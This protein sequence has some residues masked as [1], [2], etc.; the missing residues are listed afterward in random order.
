MLRLGRFRELSGVAANPS[1]AESVA[2]AAFAVDVSPYP[3]E[4]R[5]A[6]SVRESKQP[7]RHQR[8]SLIGH[9]HPPQ[10]IALRGVESRG[11]DDEIRVETFGDGI[12][13]EVKRGEVIGVAQALLLPRDVH[14]EPHPSARA[15]LG[16][17]PVPG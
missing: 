4:R 14:V 16:R 7:F 5:R 8:V 12:D 13:D 3:L 2:A 9:A 1:N 11:D 17:R 6:P 15:D 10:R